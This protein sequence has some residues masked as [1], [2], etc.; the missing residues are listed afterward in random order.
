MPNHTNRLLARLDSLE[1]GDGIRRARYVS[2]VLFLVCL[3]LAI[4]VGIAMAY[5]LHPGFIA[6][7]AAAVSSVIAERNALR[8][9]F[10]QW[11]TMRNYIDWR[12]VQADL[13]RDV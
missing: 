10:S 3:L 7:A 1:N 11:P 6:V 9:R 13:H 12:R 2:R 4:F 8:L 5:S